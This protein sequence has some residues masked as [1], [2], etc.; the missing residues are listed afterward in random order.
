M[1]WPLSPPAA[2][3]VSLA[4]CNSLKDIRII[5]TPLFDLYQ[6]PDFS[7]IEWMTLV[8]VAEAM[9]AGEG[10]FNSKFREL[11][12]FARSYRQRHRDKPNL[13]AA[14]QYIFE[15]GLS[16]NVRYLQF[17]IQ[18][19]QSLVSLASSTWPE[20]ETLVLTGFILD[21]DLPSMA[22]ILLQMPKLHDLRLL[23]AKR[24][25]NDDQASAGETPTFPPCTDVFSRIKHLS[26]SNSYEISGL[27]KLTSSLDRLS[28][29]AISRHP[30]IPIAMTTTEV[31]HALQ[32]LEIGGGSSTL[33]KLRI[34]T[35]DNLTVELFKKLGQ[36]CP[37]L[38][39]VE[40]E[41][42]GYR[43]GEAGFEWVSNLR[44]L[45]YEC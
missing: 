40:V 26:L 43:D 33:R 45:L 20:L 22:Q 18:Y 31:M 39:F 21:M 29:T 38:E 12:Y 17:S 27:L 3:L 10:P 34:M 24:L 35:E 28:I 15:S 41:L 42:C 36:I 4:Q 6:V 23:F 30:Q 13:M 5:D 7:R 2:L 16:K 32:N 19:L 25:Y 1:T 14:H 44:T 8:P 9:R 11:Q 37:K